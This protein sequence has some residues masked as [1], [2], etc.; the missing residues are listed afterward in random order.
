MD[1]NK[2]FT[3]VQESDLAAPRQDA[4]HFPLPLNILLQLSGILV[5]KHKYTYSYVR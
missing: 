4:G 2:A 1:A 3:V 5:R